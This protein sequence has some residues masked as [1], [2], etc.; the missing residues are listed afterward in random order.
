MGE[1]FDL[2]EYLTDG[3]E[4]IVSEAVKATLR[5]PKESAFM[6]RFAA[7]SRTASKK[8]RRALSV[9]ALL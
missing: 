9:L 6:L 2:Q 5:N 1:R 7:A 8:Q 3:V 4:R